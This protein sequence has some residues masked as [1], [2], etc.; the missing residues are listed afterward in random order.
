MKDIP[1]KSSNR[2]V[3]RKIELV[4]LLVWAFRVGVFPCF[5]L[6]QRAE[7]LDWDRWCHVPRWRRTDAIAA[8]GDD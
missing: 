4:I 6:R 1:T 7:T 5:F 2:Q 8:V 3:P